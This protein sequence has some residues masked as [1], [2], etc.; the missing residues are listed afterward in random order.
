MECGEGGR[1][2]AERAVTILTELRSPFLTEAR[3]ALE[4]CLA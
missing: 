4:E 2:H 1:C 3:A